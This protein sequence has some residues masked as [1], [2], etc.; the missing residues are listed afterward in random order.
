MASISQ[1]PSNSLKP[2]P[3]PHFYCFPVAPGWRPTPETFGDIL[4]PSYGVT[5]GVELRLGDVLLNGRLGFHGCF[6]C[7]PVL[8]LFSELQGS[9]CYE[10]FT[11]EDWRH[12]IKE[13]FISHHTGCSGSQSCPEHFLGQDF[14]HKTMLRTVILQLARRVSQKQSDRSQKARLV[15]LETFPEL[16]T[17]MD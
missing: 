14:K 17:L 1:C 15:H 10:V 3:R 5:V 2:L 13:V 6:P 9:C 16:W 4:Y 8:L 7:S 11:R 12:E